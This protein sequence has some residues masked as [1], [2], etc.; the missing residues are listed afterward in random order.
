M[1]ESPLPLCPRCSQPTA[2]PGGPSVFCSHCRRWFRR[3]GAGIETIESG[4]P[5]REWR[6]LGERP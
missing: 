6:P 1:T 3:A 5:L 4:W 2:W